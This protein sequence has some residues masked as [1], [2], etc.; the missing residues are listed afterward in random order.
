MKELS[1]FDFQEF[2]DLVESLHK[3]P[4]FDRSGNLVEN[5]P[6]I[7]HY[8]EKIIKGLDNAI[9]SIRSFVERLDV[10]LNIKTQVFGYLPQHVSY[11]A[12][13]DE[14]KS[15]MGNYPYLQR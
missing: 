2:V 4:L 13:V 3:S 9:Q 10:A 14:I 1:L 6:R 7:F 8:L 11:R 15:K 5:R 12:E